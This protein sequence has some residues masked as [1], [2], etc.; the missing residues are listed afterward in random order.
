VISVGKLS[1]AVGTFA[2]IDPSIE[3]YVCR[4]LR[5]SP[6]PAST[7]VIQRDRHAEVFAA[8]AIVASSLDKFST[9]I[10]HLQR[11]E[12]LEVEEFFSAGQ[13]GSSAMPHKRNPVLSENLSGLAR[14]LR[15]YSV[16]A[17]ENMALWHERDISHSSAERVIAPTPPSSC[18]SPRTVPWDDG[19]A[20]RLSRP[21][22][23]KSREHPRLMYFAARS[24]RPDREGVLEGIGVRG[25][26][27]L[28]DEVMEVRAAA[29]R[30]PL[31]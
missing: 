5:L 24:P 8:L 23:K 10:R 17:M 20:P 26:P 30:A 12:V 7:Q 25:G 1:G 31:E 6:A 21:D 4:K 29:R 28:R 3:E 27:A 19:E 16:T 9:E 2:N 18:T 14:L 11:T 15:G 22:A 13:K